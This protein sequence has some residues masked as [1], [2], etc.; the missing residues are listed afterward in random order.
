MQYCILGARL[1]K[2]LDVSLSNVVGNAR[3]IDA[4]LKHKWAWIWLEKEVNGIALFNFM[5]KVN[6]PS[7][8]LCDWCDREVTYSG[9]GL[10]SLDQH[11]ETFKHKAVASTQK[12]HYALPSS[13]ELL[14]CYITRSRDRSSWIITSYFIIEA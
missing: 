11:T 10:S 3:E 13:F 2:W 4:K 1:L 8:A 9:K 14:V 12:S 7:I 5:K 6:K